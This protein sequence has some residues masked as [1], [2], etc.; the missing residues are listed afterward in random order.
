MSDVRQRARA[1]S[2]HVLNYATNHIVNRVPSY[3]AR[4][5]W[6]QRIVGVEIGP[7][8]AVQLGCHLWTYGPGQ[9]RRDHVSIGAR[10]IVNRDCCIDA[11]APLRIG[12][13]VSISAE[14]A[15][16]T[17]EHDM[18]D[19]AFALV[20]KPVVI[21]DHVWIGMR[22]TLLPGVRIGRGAVVAAGAVVTRDVPPLQV[23]AGVPARQVGT[24]AIDP[25]YHLADTR[26]LFE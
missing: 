10:S 24:R 11:R 26:L 9:V 22:A 4:H 18:N 21:E 7:D 19:A 16:L 17:T 8:A 20:G 3:R 13:D 1:L 14:V 15:I 12:D 6:Y 5:A 23:V 25:D 2:G